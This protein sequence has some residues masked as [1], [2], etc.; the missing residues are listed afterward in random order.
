MNPHW[1]KFSYEQNI[2]LVNLDRIDTFTLAANG[3][4]S[5]WLPNS[6]Q[7]KIVLNSQNHPESYRQVLDYLTNV[8]I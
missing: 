7:I 2:Y 1:I 5:F 3:G 8:L 6:K 4:L